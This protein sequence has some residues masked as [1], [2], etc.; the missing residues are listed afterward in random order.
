MDE[1]EIEE[2]KGEL[3]G[4]R[5]YMLSILAVLLFA[6]CVMFLLWDWLLPG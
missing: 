3:R 1:F 4:E 6:I 2:T 5:S